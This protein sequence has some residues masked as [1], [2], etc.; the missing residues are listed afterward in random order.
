[1]HKRTALITTTLLCC[2]SAVAAQTRS[3]D[4]VLQ[5][6]TSCRAI[7][8]A[9]ARLECFDKAAAALEG[10]V[11]AKEITI[12]DRQEV[13]QARR[14][15]FGFAIPRIGLFDG[16]R[17]D[18]DAKEAEFAELNTTVVS[19][20]ATANGRVELRLAEGA[21]V[22]VTTDPVPFPPRPGAKV[23]IRRGALGNYFIA[24]DGQRSVRGMRVR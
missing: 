20:R 10:A 16:G 2:S 12:V 17:D 4:G 6:F 7:E 3:S 5:S 23:R 18:K 9:A 11:R 24:I 8:T 21:A 1:M 19:A 22:W 13:R 14:S 15:L